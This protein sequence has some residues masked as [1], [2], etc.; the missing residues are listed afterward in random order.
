MQSVFISTKKEGKQNDKQ[1]SLETIFDRNCRVAVHNERGHHTRLDVA[2]HG[3]TAGTG[4]PDPDVGGREFVVRVGHRL[5]P[6]RGVV[7]VRRAG[8]PMG[9]Q[10]QPADHRAHG[11][12]HVGGP[13]VRRHVSGA[14]GRAVRAGPAGGRR[15]HRAAGVRGRDRRPEDQGRPGHHVPDNDVRGH[16]VRVRGRHVP[17]LHAAHVRRDGGPGGVLRAVRRHTRVAALLRD[18]EPAGRRQTGAGLAARRRN[19]QH[20]GR[21]DG[22]R[23]RVHMQGD[24]QRV[25][26]R[27]VYRLG[28]PQGAHHRARP[29]RV[30]GD[31]GRHGAHIVRVHHVR[32]DARV[33][34][35]QQAVAGVRVLGA[36][37]GAAVHRAGRPGGPPAAHDRVVRVLLRVRHGHIRV[38]LRGQVHRVRRHRVRVAVRGGRRRAVRRAHARPRLAAVHHQLRAVPVQHPVHSQRGQHHH[39]DRRVVPGPKDLPRAGRRRRHVP[40]LSDIVAVQPH[41]HSQ[42]HPVAARDQGQDVRR[43]TGPAQENGRSGLNARAPSS[44]TAALG[45]GGENGDRYRFVDCNIFTAISTRCT[46][47]TH[48]L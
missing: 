32:R 19:R 12:G 17:G 37:L 18:E 7:A 45:R 31:G 11:A 4:Q 41:V 42:L 43:H 44:P 14:A 5:G 21:R 33:R 9:A 20:G 15:V 1:R 22:R 23:G 10:A 48:I 28:E 6:D 8:R 30:P 16:T 24:A 40:Q 39:A 13:A 27:A 47:H 3:G 29:V 34:R 36:V 35:R 38:L 26:H 2:D 46:L 25:L